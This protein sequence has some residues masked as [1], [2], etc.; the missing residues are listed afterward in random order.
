MTNT[1]EKPIYRSP[2]A[3]LRAL[4]RQ[5]LAGSIGR[6]RAIL[7]GFSDP[8][9]LDAA[10]ALLSGEQ[11]QTAL[12]GVAGLRSQRVTVL[13]S[14]TLDI[15]PNL[16]A[17]I[18]LR[19]GVVAQTRLAGFNQWRFEV[20][21]GGSLLSEH[22]PQVTLCLLDDEAVFADIGDALDMGEVEAR[23][24]RFAAELRE[25]AS[26]CR[27][28]TGGR[29]VL[30]TIPLSPLRLA[31]LI[32]YR[33]RARLASAW[34]AMNAAILALAA[35]EGGP[36]VLALAETVAVAGAS[37]F[38]NHRMHHVAGQAYAPD[39]LK[40]VAEE[41]ATVVK[42]NLGLAKKCLVL[43]LDNTLW[44]GVVGDV[45]TAGL[46]IGGSYPGSAHLELQALARDYMRQG[47]LLTVCSK[48]D[49]AN[50][51]DALANH[52]EMVLRPDN[53]TVITANWQPKAENIRAQ[54]KTINIGLDAMVFVDDHPVERDAVHSFLPEVAVVNVPDDPAGYAATLAAGNYF[55][56][57]ELTE[58]DRQRVA[59]YRAE[60]ARTV[61]QSESLSMDTYLAGLQSRLSIEPLNELNKGRIVQLFAKTNQFNL[62][63]RRFTA[64]EIIAPNLCVFGARLSDRFGDSGLIAALAISRA[65]DGSA[66]IEN[67]IMSCRVFSR[68]VETLLI[69]LLLRAA[70]TKA[71]PSVTGRFVKTAKN[72]Q[73]AEF[74]PKLGFAAEGED[75]FRHSLKSLP[76]TPDYLEITE[77]AEAFHGI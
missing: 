21:S 12:T 20:L 42:A 58:E 32:D 37:P 16:L 75:G 60:A 4:K 44:G 69:T 17:A 29:V 3:E 39:F 15:L 50:A 76:E 57:L 68:G 45:G 43:D 67:V 46:E 55:N 25:W 31:R 59:M 22:K 36:L 49:D 66:V 51:R 72:G 41:L 40:C 8:L 53:F 61:L 27:S 38:A 28:L 26:S 19:D 35:Q 30:T 62:T 23:L 48:N 11:E 13:G 77:G 10:G 6:V 70:Q 1:V 74:Y 73:F 9:D 14:S 18:L 24:G 65:D 63:G 7:A 52:P 56:L 34:S 33:S 54:A 2:M 47:V 64:D 71:L 5:D